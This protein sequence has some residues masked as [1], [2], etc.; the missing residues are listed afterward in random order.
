MSAVVFDT[1]VNSL[2]SM[3]V[4]ELA[5]CEVCL[6]DGFL[7]FSLI[8]KK[9]FKPTNSFEAGAVAVHRILPEDVESSP[10]SSSASLPA[11][12]YVVAHNVDF[13]VRVMKISEE[14][15]QICTLALCR[16]IWPQFKSHSLTAMFLE[17]KGMNRENVAAIKDAHSAYNDVVFLNAIL[18]SIVIET[19]VKSF[20][21][22]YQLSEQARIPE[23]M[24]FGKHKGTKISEL[25][26][27][28]IEWFLRQPDIDP[29]LKKAFINRL[30]M[31]GR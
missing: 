9:R 12:E 25:D 27:G 31:R 10:P 29:Y 19:R 21:E 2:E 3:E 28:Y 22:L 8:T 16:R 23:V 5:F 6:L 4:I 7:G 17:L 14:K 20:E 13:D 15:K 30:E 11:G 18:E 1:E 24:M 26:F